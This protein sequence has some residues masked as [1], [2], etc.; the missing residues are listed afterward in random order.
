[1]VRTQSRG[2]ELANTLS[3]GIGLLLAGAAVPA[4]FGGTPSANPRAVVG[5]AVFAATLLLLYL[6]SALYHALPPGRAKHVCR[7]LDHQAIFLAIA[8]TYTPFTLGVLSGPWGWALLVA[9]WSAALAGIALKAAAGLRHPGLSMA[10]YLGMGWLVLVAIEPLS[11]RMPVS[12]LVW[13]LAGGL[14]YT[15]GLVFYAAHGRRYC[16]FAW[17]L[18]VLTGTLCHFVAVLHYAAG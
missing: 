5:N 11:Q 16:H 15:G 3:H 13:L 2:E 1:M 17:H 18:C 12:G 6:V 10:L 9:V 8:G 7:L 4:L 14:A